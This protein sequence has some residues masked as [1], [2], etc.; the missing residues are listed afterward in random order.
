M[1]L[2]KKE[3]EKKLKEAVEEIEKYNPSA[4]IYLILIGGA[5]L[6]LKYRLPYIGGIGDLLSRKGFQIVA[7]A[8]LNLPPDYEERLEPIIESRKVHVF[9]LSPYDLA[10]SKIS[11]G[12]SKDIEDILNSELIDHINIERLKKIYFDAMNYWTRRP[13]KVCAGMGGF[14]KCLQKESSI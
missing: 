5:S 1:S 8:L 10:V 11:R 6:I 9:S 14:R 4:D 7:E 2:S 13:Q 12:F 3:I